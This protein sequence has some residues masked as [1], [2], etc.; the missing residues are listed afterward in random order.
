[1]NYRITVWEQ[2]LGRP[3]KVGEVACEIAGDGMLRSAFRYSTV[4]ER[5]RK[6]DFTTDLH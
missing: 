5:A 3:R 2:T 1:M 4:R 6:E